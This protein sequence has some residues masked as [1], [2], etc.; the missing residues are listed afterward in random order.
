MPES[1]KGEA[2][3]VTCGIELVDWSVAGKKKR[4]NLTQIFRP[5]RPSAVGFQ[6][7]RRQ[8]WLSSLKACSRSVSSKAPAL[9][10]PRNSKNMAHC[11]PNWKRLIKV[12]HVAQV[13]FIKAFPKRADQK[14][15]LDDVSMMQGESD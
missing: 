1:E 12:P 8:S 5:E 13:A 11:V 10:I 3:P 4:I 6:F 15:A 7:A 9:G 14:D 2:R